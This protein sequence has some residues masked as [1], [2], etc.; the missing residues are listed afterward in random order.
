MCSEVEA[1]ESCL[2]T[3]F[4]PWLCRLEPASS[5]FEILLS[6]PQARGLFTASLKAKPR[7][8]GPSPG[9]FYLNCEVHKEASYQN[10]KFI[11]LGLKWIRHFEEKSRFNEGKPIILTNAI[12]S[13][14]NHEGHSSVSTASSNHWK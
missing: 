11:L 6:E 14:M 7:P 4:K 5:F 8:L 12:R 13:Q 10:I 2:Q 3:C 1:C 9:S